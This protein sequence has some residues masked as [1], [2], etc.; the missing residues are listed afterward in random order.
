[1]PDDPATLEY[2]A[3]YGFSP[4]QLQFLT[5]LNPGWFAIAVQ[6]CTP[7]FYQH[8]LTPTELKLFESDAAAKR[9][10]QGAPGEGFAVM[11]EE[12]IRALTPNE[13]DVFVG[14]TTATGRE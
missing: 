9:M 10:V 8:I 5:Q 14:E 13:G 6:G 3:K 2:Y 7:I 11:P 4:Q 1:M 12:E